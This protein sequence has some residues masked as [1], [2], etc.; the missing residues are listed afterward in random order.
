MRWEVTVHP[1]S[2]SLLKVQISNHNS[3]MI[4]FEWEETFDWDKVN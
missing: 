1:K 3:D 4:N 2:P